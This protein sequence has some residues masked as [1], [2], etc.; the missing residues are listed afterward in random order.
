MAKINCATSYLE[1]LLEKWIIAIYIDLD[2]GIYYEVRGKNVGKIAYDASLE[3][4]LP[5]F[6]F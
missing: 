2:A 5:V 3:K 4:N 1:W 6:V